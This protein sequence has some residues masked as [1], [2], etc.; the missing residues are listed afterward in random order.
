MP[1][2]FQTPDGFKNGTTISDEP[3]Q[4]TTQKPKY[5][6][7]KRLGKFIKEN[8]GGVGEVELAVKF[9]NFVDDELTAQRESIA[10]EIEGVIGEDESLPHFYTEKTKEKTHC[11]IERNELRKE[12]RQRLSAKMKGK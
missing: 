3:M 8:I 1:V 12:Q 10:K 2:I 6:T 9:I 11:I 7:K 4:T 5:A